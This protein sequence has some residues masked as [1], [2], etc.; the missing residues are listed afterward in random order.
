M[1]A[2]KRPRSEFSSDGSDLPA[3]GYQGS[4][5]QKGV[6]SFSV[7]LH[8]CLTEEL[9]EWKDGIQCLQEDNSLLTRR[10]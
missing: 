4:A 7:T 8:S 9:V 5:S 10:D 1:V 2:V 6:V 3:L